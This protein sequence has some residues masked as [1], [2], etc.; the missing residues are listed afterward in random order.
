MTS[1]P[2]DFKE[3]LKNFF[4]IFVYLVSVGILSH[5][6]KNDSSNWLR[7]NIQWIKDKVFR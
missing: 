5:Y 6:P 4:D 7:K 1:M 3:I 2:Q